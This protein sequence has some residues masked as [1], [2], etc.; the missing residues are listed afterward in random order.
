MKKVIHA[1]PRHVCLGFIS[2]PYH[3]I[4]QQAVGCWSTV[5][6]GAVL[7]R[8]RDS[9]SLSYSYMTVFLFLITWIQLNYLNCH[10]YQKHHYFLH[11]LYFFSFLIRGAQRTGWLSRDFASRQDEKKNYKVKLI[12]LWKTWLI[13]YE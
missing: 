1:Q 12:T 7:P 10:I 6:C 4:V 9:S 3:Y 11:F 8:S 5:H 13:L 2:I